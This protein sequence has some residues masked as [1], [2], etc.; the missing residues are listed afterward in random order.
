MPTSKLTTIET[1]F[2]SQI[3]TGTTLEGALAGTTQSVGLYPW[4][5]VI[6][7][8]ENTMYEANAVLDAEYTVTVL[9]ESRDCETTRYAVEELLSLFTPFGGANAMQA[10]GVNSINP[11][12]H[13]MPVP[14]NPPANEPYYGTVTYN[15]VV[16]YTY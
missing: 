3:V 7:K 1:E 2:L 12:S 15:M 16:R 9:V 6:F 8:A 13:E 14:I 11:I 5:F 4:A 10:M